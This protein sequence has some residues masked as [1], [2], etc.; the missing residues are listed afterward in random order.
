MLG[1]DE[2]RQLLRIGALER[3]EAGR[4]PDLRGEPIENALGRFGTLR[5]IENTAGVL[6]AALSGKSVLRRQRIEF[7]EDSLAGVGGNGAERRQFLDDGFDFFLVKVLAH[8]ARGIFAERQQKN[9]GLA[10]ARHR[11]LNC[12]ISALVLGEPRAEQVGRVFG[13]ALRE[14]RDALGQDRHPLRTGH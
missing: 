6:H 3:E 10:G 1:K 9:G 2:F 11:D 13:F 5:P 14:R 4:R 12:H 8:F 7:V